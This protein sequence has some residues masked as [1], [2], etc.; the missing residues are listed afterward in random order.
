MDKKTKH[1]HLVLDQHD[2]DLYNKYYKIKNPYSR[3]PPIDKP[4]H[5]TLN[6]WSVMPRPAANAL[7][8]KWTDFICF[9]MKSQ[10]LNGMM[11][12]DLDVEMTVYVSNHRRMDIDGRVPKFILD[13]W[14]ECGFIVDDCYTYLH[15]LTLRIEYDKNHERTEFDIYY[16]Q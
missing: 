14:T 8:Q 11:L 15:S 2:V 4:L 3:K 1:L 10:N 9:W 12:D 5:P 16:R 7:K 6:R 13:A